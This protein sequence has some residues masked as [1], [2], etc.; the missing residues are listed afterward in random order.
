M[1]LS[2]NEKIVLKA[3]GDVETP[4]RDLAAATGLK[5][6]AAVHAG[7]LLEE[8]GLASVRDEVVSAYVL[9]DEGRKYAEA[10]LPERVI[11]GALPQAGATLKD[12]KARFPPATVSIAMGWLRQKGWAKFEKRDGDTVLLPLA[13][14]QSEDEAA[15]AALLDGKPQAELQE[16]TMR[17]LLKRN[18]VLVREEKAKMLR[19]TASGAA[20]RDE[21]IEV[22][23]EIGQLTP[24]MIAT[25]AWQ[26]KDFRRFDVAA[27]VQRDYGGRK[28]IL[29][30]ALDGVKRTLIEMG[31][32][33]MEGPLIDAEFYVNDLLFM[34]QDHPAR[35]QWDQFNLKNPRHIRRLPRELVHKVRDIH[36]YGGDTGSSGWNYA[37][38]ERIAKKLVLRGHT[39]SLTARYLAKFK[40]PPQKFF[41]VAPV[42][43][44]DTI[45]VTHLLEFYQIE[46]WVMDDGLS[47]RDLMGTFR[48]FYA[49]LGITGLRFKPTYNPYT[50]PSLE[51]YG[52]HPR[53]GRMIEVGNSGMFRKE[54]LAAYGIDSDVIA[55]GLALERILMILYGYEDIRDLHGPLC[56]ID[57]LRSVPVIWQN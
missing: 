56:D 18:L 52:R 26:G 12:L 51:I 5:V 9:T 40:K 16:N 33:E 24:E 39:T 45:D 10:G 27:P 6:E 3:V 31:F 30:M 2:S 7:Y 49:R 50:E 32:K 8:K 38:D 4:A 13:A 41:S 47:M 17:G 54:M 57:F 23:E 53:T 14:G 25:G 20:L 46:G 43:R 48:E 22:R 36:E 34:P 55:W 11:F 15:L 35:T 29:R 44:N 37:W 42:F 1:D 19:I 28:H 21:G